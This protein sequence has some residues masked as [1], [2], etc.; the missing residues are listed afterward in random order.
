MNAEIGK[1]YKHYKNE[2]EYTVI[3]VGYFTESNPLLECVVYRAEYNTDDL[4]ENPVFIRPRDM[5]EETIDV[6][7]KVMDRFE[8]IG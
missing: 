1:V 2:K 3:A 5:F 7:G 8:L 4:G 6:D